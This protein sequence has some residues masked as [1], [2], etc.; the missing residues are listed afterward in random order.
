MS[1][2]PLSVPRLFSLVLIAGLALMLL[3]PLA[4]AQ[5]P[6]D[7]PDTSDDEMDWMFGA[8][9]IAIIVVLLIVNIVILLW[10]YKDAQARGKG[11]EAIFWI[12]AALVGGPIV[13]LIW[14]LVRPDLLPEG[15]QPNQPPYP[16]GPPPGQGGMG[17]GH[18]PPPP[19][20][21]PYDD[22]GQEPY[23]PPPTGSPPR[24]P[25]P[26]YPPPE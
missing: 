17:P 18:Y 19:D 2:T 5:G 20:Y 22:G 14:L 11:E 15:Y 6:Y 13:C 25:P 16:P 12:I 4:I 23:P 7:E 10:L 24:Y 8:G 21:P 26:Q 1:S 9:C 3:A